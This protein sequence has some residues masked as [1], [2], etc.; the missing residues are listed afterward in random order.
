MGLENEV[1][2]NLESK[3]TPGFGAKEWLRQGGGHRD[4]TKNVLLYVPMLD[5]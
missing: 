2:F 1:V 4:E 5:T 3:R